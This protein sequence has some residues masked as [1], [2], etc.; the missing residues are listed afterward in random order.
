MADVN[1]G[2]L[3]HYTLGDGKEHLEFPNAQLT[4]MAGVLCSKTER[5]F[6][7]QISQRAVVL[8]PEAVRRSF[9]WTEGGEDPAC[10][11]EEAP[12]VNIHA[13]DSSVVPIV[14]PNALSCIRTPY[15]TVHRLSLLRW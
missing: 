3:A 9:E 4:Q 7:V 2:L 13:K 8:S 10:G 1:Q 12:T 15:C 6:P 14:C 5:H 11:V